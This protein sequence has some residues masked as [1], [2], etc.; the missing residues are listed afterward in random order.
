VLKAAIDPATRDDTDFG[1]PLATRRILEAEFVSLISA[2]SL[3]GRLA[4]AMLTV[5]FLTRVI[6]EST[7]PVACFVGEFQPLPVSEIVMDYV[8]LGRAKCQRRPKL[9]GRRY[10]GCDVALACARRV[11][12]RNSSRPRRASAYRAPACRGR[13]SIPQPP[14]RAS[15]IHPL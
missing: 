15:I 7:P 3:V 6:R 8:E 9:D 13:S 1:V 4:A 2:R 14:P 5:P 10:A 12:A 11:R